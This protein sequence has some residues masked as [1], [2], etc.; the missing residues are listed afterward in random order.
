MMT[1]TNN[2]Q[3]TSPFFKL[4]REVRDKIYSYLPNDYFKF[5]DTSDDK[6]W[7]FIHGYILLNP[8]LVSRQ[9]SSEYREQILRDTRVEIDLRAGDRARFERAVSSAGVRSLL[10]QVRNVTV[11]YYDQY[12]GARTRS[13]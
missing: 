8:C 4:P 5:D 12:S 1:D 10:A 7:L 2:Q 3:Q 11:F 13:K 9:F 6:G